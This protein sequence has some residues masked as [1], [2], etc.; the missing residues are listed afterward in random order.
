MTNATADNNK[1]PFD[2]SPDQDNDEID[3]GELL[4]IFI[5]GKWY[6]ILIAIVFLFLV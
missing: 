4:G 5:D 1:I 6:I 3:L 2:Y